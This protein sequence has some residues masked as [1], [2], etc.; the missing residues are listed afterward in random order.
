MGQKANPVPLLYMMGINDATITGSAWTSGTGSYV[1]ET[2]RQ[3]TARNGA[4]T[5]RQGDS[6]R[7]DAL[8]NS[9][10]PTADTFAT[11]TFAPVK[12]NG[13]E[14]K[15]IIFNAGHTWP[16]TN[17]GGGGFSATG[18]AIAFFRR[19]WSTPNIEDVTFFE[20]GWMHPVLVNHPIL[21]AQ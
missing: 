20:H 21:V 14:V 9:V 5:P 18:E 8:I 1:F 2:V 15:L 16:N 10:S 7:L 12:P 13:E 19:H 4:E 11:T 3:V 17:P 6:S